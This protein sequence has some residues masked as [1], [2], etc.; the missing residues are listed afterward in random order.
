MPLSGWMDKDTVVCS[1]RAAAL[2]A[3]KKWAVKPQGHGKLRCTGIRE[4]GPFGNPRIPGYADVVGNQYKFLWYLGI[5]GIKG[6]GGKVGETQRILGQWNNT[7][8]TSGVDECLCTFMMTP[9]MFPSKTKPW[10]ERGSWQHIR[11]CPCDKGTRVSGC[12]CWGTRCGVSEGST[13]N[14]GSLLLSSAVTLNLFWQHRW[15]K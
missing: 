12:W 2:S 6:W 4:G 11:T 7:W 8:V 10:S 15:K 9:K 3:Q 5:R 13:G 1:D 14:S